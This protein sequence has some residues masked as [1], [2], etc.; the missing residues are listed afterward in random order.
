MP[1]EINFNSPVIANNISKNDNK[2]KSDISI[3]YSMQ[4]N[5][6]N[7]LSLPKSLK[8]NNVL[9]AN[10]K[11]ISSG[12][13]IPTDVMILSENQKYNRNNGLSQLNDMTQYV[14]NNNHIFAIPDNLSMNLT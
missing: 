6:N 3:N 4:K 14:D 7:T 11:N 1:E 10:N 2:V 13:S 9:R 5:T 8:G 12:T